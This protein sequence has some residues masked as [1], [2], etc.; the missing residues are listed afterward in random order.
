VHS[1]SLQAGLV[2]GTL[3][4]TRHAKTV[5]RDGRAIAPMLP[6]H[7]IT[8]PVLLA[9]IALSLLAGCSYTFLT[10]MLPTRFVVS[11]FL[12]IPEMVLHM[13]PFVIAF[14]IGTS[15]CGLLLK[16][17]MF[18]S[19]RPIIGWVLVFVGN[20]LL[21]AIDDD[22][23][24]DPKMSGYLMLVGLG[25]GIACASCT[26]GGKSQA[27][28]VIQT[29]EL[30]TKPTA[31]LHCRAQDTAI[32]QGLVAQ[33]RV[34]GGLFA[35][36]GFSSIFNRQLLSHLGGELTAEQIVRI[37]VNHRSLDSLTTL[38]KYEVRRNFM[39]A[40]SETVGYVAVS[41]TVGIGI[42]IFVSRQRT[43][44]VERKAREVE[45]LLVELYKSKLYKSKLVEAR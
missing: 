20:G 14:A 4:L 7:V 29:S 41:A 5:W 44:N 32:V 33:A 15:T 45:G 19:I 22:Y 40:F 21:M 30:L 28:K 42:S 18:T 39:A 23:D 34:H 12:T 38:Q 6:L 16:R 13:A 27:R 3:S 11:N 24:V 9:Q 36:A 25:T 31:T 17:P 1:A 8:N 43:Y 10:I 26:F 2:C 37:P 35:T